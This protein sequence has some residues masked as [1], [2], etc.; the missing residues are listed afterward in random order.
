MSFKRGELTS[1]EIVTIVMAIA[2]FILVAI[3]LAIFFD[4]GSNQDTELCKLSVLSRATSP[5]LTQS[6]V[7]LK[8]TTGKIC[9]TSELLGRDCKQFLGEKGVRKVRIGASET[10]DARIKEEM[11]NAMYDCWNMM[12]QGKL[13]LFGQA[14]DYFGSPDYPTCVVCSRIAFADDV[15]DNTIV[16]AMQGFDNYLQDNPVPN[17]D[18]SYLRYFNGQASTALGSTAEIKS[19]LDQANKDHNNSAPASVTITSDRQIAFVFSQIRTKDTSEV[20]KN[21]GVAAA[22]ATFVIPGAATVG[23][24]LFLTEAAVVTVPLAIVGVGAV[25]VNNELAQNAAAGYCGKLTSTAEESGCS[26]VQALPYSV[27]AMRALCPSSIQ[28]SP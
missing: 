10:S 16:R 12:G 22:G 9:I 23:R 11:A 19:K 21:L 5:L 27:S 7:P 17:H 15:D 8:C 28:G 24:A 1:S 6:I 2:G 26:V 18:Y 3:F 25:A 20:L 13:D 14:G 4:D